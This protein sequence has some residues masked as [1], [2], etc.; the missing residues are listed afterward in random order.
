M[1]HKYKSLKET[2]LFS[3]SVCLTLELKRGNLISKLP[4]G[5][6]GSLSNKEVARQVCMPGVPISSRNSIKENGTSS[7]K[8]CVVN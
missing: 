7:V 6:L 1:S 8:Q 3:L 5:S 2:N 4:P